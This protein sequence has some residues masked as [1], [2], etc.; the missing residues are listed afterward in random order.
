MNLERA[1]RSAVST[2]TQGLVIDLRNNPG[3]LLTSAVDIAS[4]LL[5]EKSVVVIEENSKGDRKELKTHSGDVFRNFRR[6]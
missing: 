5:P 3:G 2:H 4:F 1:I 6:A